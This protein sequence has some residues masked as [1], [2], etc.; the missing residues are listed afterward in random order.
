[1]EVEICIRFKN[2]FK[3]QWWTETGVS[4]DYTVH[5]IIEQHYWMKIEISINCSISNRFERLREVC[6]IFEMRYDRVN[7]AV[8]CSIVSYNIQR[9]HR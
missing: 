6:E 7:G 5:N 8:S 1:M 2:L 3:Q 4:T 9:T